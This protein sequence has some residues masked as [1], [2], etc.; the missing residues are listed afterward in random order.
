MLPVVHSDNRDRAPL[1]GY[2][3]VPPEASA[4]RALRTGATR[5]SAAW[6]AVT[7]FSAPPPGSFLPVGAGGPFSERERVRN[8]T[9]SL[10][11]ASWRQL[12]LLSR[13]FDLRLEAMAGSD[14]PG[15]FLKPHS[16]S[17]LLGG[18]ADTIAPS[19]RGS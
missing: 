15:H 14:G 13:P 3:A 11:S 18:T 5:R 19:E 12:A 1:R 4:Y 10:R 7:L 8:G 2:F 16:R 6:S 17:L 9:H